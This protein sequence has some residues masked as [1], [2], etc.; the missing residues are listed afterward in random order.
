MIFLLVFLILSRISTSVYFF[1]K[2]FNEKKAK[3]CSYFE[4]T[5]I[6][7]LPARCLKFYSK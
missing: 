6:Q 5:T 4:N 3:P 7:Y 2:E 1:G